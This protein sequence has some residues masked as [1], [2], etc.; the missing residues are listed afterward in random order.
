M[1]PERNR[2]RIAAVI[3][4]TVLV[5]VAVLVIYPH[6][7][8]VESEGNGTVSH[9]GDNTLRFYRD[10]TLNI[11]PDHGYTA[12]VYVD[13]TLKAEDVTE[14]TFKV[15]ILD[16]SPHT[17]KVV[18][19]KETP[20]VVE[21]TL[22][23]T[24]EGDGTVT[25]SGTS[26]HPEGTTVN[27]IASP[28]QSSTISDVLIDGVSVGTGN[29][30]RIIMDS[31]HDVRVVFRPSE[32]TDIPVT[33]SVDISV[34][35][36]VETLGYSGDLDFGTVY[37]SGTV[38][39]EPHGSLTILVL[40]NEG[41]E[42]RDMRIDGTSLGAVTEH[43]IEDITSSVA[44]ELSIVKRVNGFMITASAGVGGSISPSGD[45]KV[46]EGDDQTFRFY[47]ASGYKISHLII[48]GVR[49]DFQGNS[50]TFEDVT[51][52]HSIEAVF[53]YSGGGGSTVTLTGIEVSE[54]PT[55]TEYVVGERFDPSGMQVTAAYSD[56][57]SHRVEPTSYSPLVFTEPG[58]Q[59]VT[60]SYSEEGRTVTTTVTV[61]V[62]SPSLD[63]LVYSVEGTC[64]EDGGTTQF[65]DDYDGKHLSEFTSDDPL[66]RTSPVF[67]GMTQSAMMAVSAPQSE[68][69]AVRVTVGDCDPELA[70]SIFINVRIG[71]DQRLRSLGE[72]SSD[73][74]LFDLSDMS[75]E[76][77]GMTVTIHMIDEGD[78]SSLMGKSLD[79][80]LEVVATY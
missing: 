76:F 18:F 45:V 40:L 13:G 52:A 56:G 24:S 79:F 12:E 55:K 64:I 22:T 19:V 7:V 77:I 17:I 33:V 61:K 46:A 80:T 27:V 32:P 63:V 59:E 14:Y 25:P 4:A 5:V 1:N 57:T 47:A 69:L 29:V 23:V 43:T 50:Y 72:L 35:I 66:F 6:H 34:D 75:E 9:S 68:S 71:D 70:S 58:K 74:L 26:T 3:M 15:S 78:Q 44:V 39:V 20:V 42:V 8:E 16:L 49:V 31:D 37:P 62:L 2:E 53:A 51:S 73:P 54:P 38:H 48:D 65:H 41:F 28:S 11:S 21:Q 36:I 67:P 60:V 10:L 30:I